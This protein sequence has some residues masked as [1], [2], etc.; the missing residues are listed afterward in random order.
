MSVRSQLDRLAEIVAQRFGRPDWRRI[1]TLVSQAETGRGRFALPDGAD[2]EVV[3][4][5]TMVAQMETS[6][7]GPPGEPG[8][9]VRVGGKKIWPPEE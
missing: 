2:P 6:M 8:P 7:P 9:E 1:T 3:A 4:L 5:A